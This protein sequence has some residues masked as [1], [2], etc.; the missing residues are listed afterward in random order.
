MFK[1]LA[2]VI[3][4]STGQPIDVLVSNATIAE[5]PPSL[6]MDGIKDRLQSEL[7]KQNDKIKVSTLECVTLEEVESTAKRLMGSHAI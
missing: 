7:E 2:L 3:A 6:L 1:I 5:C 4:I